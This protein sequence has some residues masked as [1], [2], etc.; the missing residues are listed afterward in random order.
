ML[1]LLATRVN[2][3]L[4]F[5][6]VV[7]NRRV[8]IRARSRCRPTLGE[9]FFSLPVELQLEI[10]LFMSLD[11]VLSLG[12]TCQA[13][14]R[15]ISGHEVLLAKH[16]IRILIPEDHTLLYPIPSPPTIKYAKTVEYRREASE[17]LAVEMG[18]HLVKDMGQRA[19]PSMAQY[20]ITRLTTRMGPAIFYL[21]HFFEEY[22]KAKEQDVQQVSPDQ[23]VEHELN[24]QIKILIQ[25]SDEML[26]RMYQ[27]YH[28]GIQLFWRRMTE[29]PN[30]LARTLL[31]RLYRLGT[32]SIPSEV[33]FAKLLLLGGIPAVSWLYK[34]KGAKN[35]MKA[36]NSYIFQV[37]KERAAGAVHTQSESLA[38]K[39]ATDI[40]IDNFEDIWMTAAHK[41]I[42]DRNL[43][44]DI[45][46]IPV[47]GGFIAEL[48]GMSAAAQAVAM[49]VAEEAS[50]AEYLSTPML[51]GINLHAYYDANLPDDAYW[52]DNFYGQMEDAE[53]TEDDED[54]AGIGEYNLTLCNWDRAYFRSREDPQLND[55]GLALTGFYGLGMK[56]GGKQGN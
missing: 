31:G 34:I 27:T 20:I 46:D 8:L 2:K 29:G 24:M 10:T 14:R 16:H 43:V 18:K 30:W 32:I 21:L 6:V 1:Q 56:S 7:M 23:I 50:G 44:N 11:D 17:S 12:Q 3:G 37:D 51:T 33:T 45:D 13:F 9:L 40:H 49:Q 22:R 26:M 4:F 19:N 35:R 54:A 39:P 48:L 42:M 38:G 36:L 55:I 25:Y 41:N 15:L 53:D 5:P 52:D 47:N 28:L